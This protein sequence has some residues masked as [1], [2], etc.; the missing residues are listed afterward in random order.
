[1]LI[2]DDDPMVVRMLKMTFDLEGYTV[3]T[4]ADGEEGLRC[5]REQMP[6]IILCDIMMPK[7]DGLAVTRALKGDAATKAIPI[8]LCSAKTSDADVKRGKDAGA[9]DYVT[10]P[11]QVKALAAR[12]AALLA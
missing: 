2:V 7:L 9:D 3:T 4:A 11:F 10:K 8:V 12:I 6:D 1:M 5:A